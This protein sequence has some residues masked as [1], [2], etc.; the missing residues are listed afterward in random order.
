MGKSDVRPLLRLHAALGAHPRALSS[1]AAALWARTGRRIGVKD[2]AW[3]RGLG[4]AEM[5]V[6]LWEGLMAAGALPEGVLEPVGLQR[7]LNGVVTRETN[8]SSLEGGVDGARVVWTL[9][10]LHPAAGL[11]GRSLSIAAQQV[12]TNAKESIFLS[13]PFLEARG[14]GLVLD[15][16][17]V[18]L[19]H[20]VN[21]TLLGHGLLDIGS[22]QSLAVEALR[23]SVQGR[24][25]YLDIY[26]AVA[27]ADSR[28][29][30]PLLHAKLIVGDAQEALVSSAN[31]TLQGFSTNFEAGVY[32]KGEAV[33]ELA[34]VCRSLLASPLTS[35]VAR[36]E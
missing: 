30:R 14:I 12:I 7:F 35:H 31:L 23:R 4:S 1:V 15:H 27:D 10:R 21:V 20:G 19:A 29:D 32:L 22:P 26:S 3:A 8:E 36:V 33:R 17:Q 16:L 6:L 9:P 24:G 28:E 18:A 13:A 34:E 25:G 5:P 11:R 2:L